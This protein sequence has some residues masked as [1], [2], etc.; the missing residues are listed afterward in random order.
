MLQ[1]H[2]LKLHALPVLH[3]HRKVLRATVGSAEYDAYIQKQSK[4]ADKA[5]AVKIKGL[6]NDTSSTLFSDTKWAV[7]TLAPFQSA[8]KEVRCALNAAT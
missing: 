6:I 7:D 1:G 2:A 5:A 3:S 4:A 8:I